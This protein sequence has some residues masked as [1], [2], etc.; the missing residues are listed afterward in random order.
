LDVDVYAYTAYYIDRGDHAMNVEFKDTGLKKS[1]RM[2]VRLSAEAKL[3]LEHAA[4]IEGRTVTDF[5]I[6]AALDAANATIDRTQRIRLSAESSRA[7]L[8]ALANP[9][10]PN[11][12]LLEAA[13]LYR[14]HLAKL[15]R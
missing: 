8:E 7:F 15:K 4:A 13:A 1:E 11:E 3:M 10:E 12:T 9:P 2:A 6:G 14:E 5:V